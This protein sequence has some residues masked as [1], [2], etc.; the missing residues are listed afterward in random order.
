MKI[1]SISTCNYF[2]FAAVSVKTLSNFT[3]SVSDRFQ[4]PLESSQFTRCAHVRGY[5]ADYET[6]YVTCDKPVRGRFVVVYRQE[7]GQIQMCEF[8]VFGT[9]TSGKMV[10]IFKYHC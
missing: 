1:V 9:S 7:R 8:E 10:H 5:L 2:C 6:R 3:I 4:I